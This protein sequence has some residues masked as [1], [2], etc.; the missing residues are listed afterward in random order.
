MGF[1]AQEALT[2]RASLGKSVCTSRPTCPALRGS[3]ASPPQ[4]LSPE[5]RSGVQGLVAAPLHRGQRRRPPSAAGSSSAWPR[6][7]CRHPPSQQQPDERP[8]EASFHEES[9]RRQ[10]CRSEPLQG[11]AWQGQG[12]G[13]SPTAQRTGKG[14]QSPG[15]VLSLGL[16]FVT[17][18]GMVPSS[19]T[20]RHRP[21]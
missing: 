17:V 15:R 10:S 2:Q 4:Q 16:S 11:R 18:T 5:E 8:C 12:Q 20:T 14:C 3:H 21:R 13:S 1:S 19:R 9:E 7:R 6:L